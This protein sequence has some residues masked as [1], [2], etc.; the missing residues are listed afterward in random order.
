M[1]METFQ[2]NLN[3]TNNFMPYSHET[4]EIEVSFRAFRTFDWFLTAFK[5]M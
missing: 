1:R 4:R 3:I 2:A 5:E